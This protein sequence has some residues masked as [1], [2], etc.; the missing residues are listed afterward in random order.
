MKFEQE[1]YSAPPEAALLA[2]AKFPRIWKII[3]DEWGTIRLKEYLGHLLSDTRGGNRQGFP[4]EVSKALL[5]LALAN[6]SYIEDQLGITFD[7]DPASAFA[8]PDW[9]IPKNF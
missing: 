7:D 9:I 4:I 8:M 2:V 3:V 5:Q 1:I 6:T